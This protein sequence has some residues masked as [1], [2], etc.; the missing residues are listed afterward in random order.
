MRDIDSIRTFLSSQGPT[1]LFDLP[2]M[3]IYIAI[4]FYMHTTLG[5]A[6][7]V[8]AIVLVFLTL[9][10]GGSDATP[11]E[12]CCG[13]PDVTQWISR[14]EPAQFR[15][16][17]GHG[18]D[19]IGSVTDGQPLH[20]NYLTNNQQIGDVA[21][22]LGAFSRSLRLMLQSAVLG[23]GAYLVINGQATAGIIIAGS[24][25]S[26]A[27]AGA[28]RSRDCKLEGVRLCA[29]KLAAPRATFGAPSCRVEAPMQL[30]VSAAIFESVEQVSAVPPGLQKLVIAGCQFCARTRS[31]S[32]RHRP[33]RVGQIFAGKAARWSLGA[34]AWPSHDWI[35]PHYRNGHL[36]ILASSIGYLPQDVELFSGSVAENIARFEPNSESRANYCSSAM[37]QAFMT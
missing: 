20:Q 26:L 36:K 34:G 7:L 9:D 2:W 37:L 4:I 35:G 15:S 13:L 33:K 21:N 14:S 12:G 1:A 25:L 19:K 16:F 30:A 28:S 27:C 18:N 3:P 5:L 6:A 8:G 11:N 17:D 22:D 32:R 10:D 24:N 23:L 29:P 31:R